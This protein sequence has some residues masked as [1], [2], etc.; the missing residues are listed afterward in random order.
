MKADIPAV[1]NSIIG[2]VHQTRVV[3]FFDNVKRYAMGSTN[4]HNLKKEMSRGKSA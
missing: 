4:T 1:A 3:A 2:K